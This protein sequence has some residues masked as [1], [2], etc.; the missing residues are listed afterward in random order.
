[1]LAM[2][3]TTKAQAA[4]IKAMLTGAVRPMIAELL[5]RFERESGHRVSAEYGLPPALVRKMDA[6]EPFDVVILSLDVAGLIKQGRVVAD[7]R[8][9]LGRTGLGVAVRQG[10]PKPDFSTVEAFKRMLMEAKSIT[11]SGEGSSGR[12]FVILLGRLGMLDAI[13][14]KLVPPPP[15]GRAATL[16]ASGKAELAVQG[17][18]AVIP[19]AGVEWAGYLPAEL[20]DWLL[21]T[22]GVGSAAK[23]PAAARDF[24]RFLTTPGSVALFKAKGLEPVP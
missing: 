12:Y 8:T 18:A 9:V 14:P 5:P 19:V 21:F 22:G 1:M 3:L 6:G 7:S 16:V 20:N 15:T 23:E 13:K 17:L 10:A 4:E 2:M 11:Y 24:L